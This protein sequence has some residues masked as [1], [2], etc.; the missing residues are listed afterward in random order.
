LISVDAEGDVIARGCLTPALVVV[1]LYTHYTAAGRDVKRQAASLSTFQFRNRPHWH[2]S[3]LPGHRQADLDP[4][5]VITGAW[6][7][8]DLNPRECTMN[9]IVVLIILLLLFGG[10]GFYLGG[11]A[12]GGGL[13][14]LILLVLIVMLLTGRGR[15]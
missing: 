4:E 10:G 15:L 5:E 6:N 1:H 14:G 7:I 3:W 12:V 2:G 8:V 9:I 13:G 11:P